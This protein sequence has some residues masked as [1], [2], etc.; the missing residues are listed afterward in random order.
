MERSSERKHSSAAERTRNEVRRFHAE[1]NRLPRRAA[2]DVA[3]R[4]LAEKA[5]KLCC[6]KHKDYSREFHEWCVRY[7][8]RQRRKRGEPSRMLIRLF[9]LEHGHMPSVRSKCEK[10]RRLGRMLQGYCNPSSTS[11]NKEFREEMERCGYGNKAR[12]CGPGYM[13][14]EGE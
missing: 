6:R 3:E 2:G 4:R 8:R 10:E 1:F 12:W 9:I 14:G 7:S 5:A 13:T 11:Y